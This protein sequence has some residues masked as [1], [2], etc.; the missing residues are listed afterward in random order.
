MGGEGGALRRRARNG[1]RRVALLL[2]LQARAK[3]VQGDPCG[4]E[5]GFVG[6]KFA[7]PF[8]CKPLALKLNLKTAQP[9]PHPQGS[10]FRLTWILGV[11]YLIHLPKCDGFEIF[12]AAQAGPPCKQN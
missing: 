7:V 3:I 5:K 12:G 9:I 4:R 6:M 10:P 11:P 8:Q 1:L 2:L